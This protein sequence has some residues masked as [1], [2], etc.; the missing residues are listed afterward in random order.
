MIIVLGVD[1]WSCLCRLNVLFLGVCF[2]SSSKE[3]VADAHCLLVN[4]IGMVTRG[5]R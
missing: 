4:L 5:S 2:L 1:I 3:S